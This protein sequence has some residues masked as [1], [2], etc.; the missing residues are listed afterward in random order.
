MECYM[1]LLTDGGLQVSKLLCLLLIFLQLNN[2][3]L[4]ILCLWLPEQ[5]QLHHVSLQFSSINVRIC[6]CFYS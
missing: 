6:D 5:K 3:P 2:H 4:Y 1:Y